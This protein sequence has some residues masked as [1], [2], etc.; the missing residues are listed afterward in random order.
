MTKMIAISTL[1]GVVFLRFWSLGSSIL[2][3]P[4]QSRCFLR[5]LTPGRLKKRRD[6]SKGTAGLAGQTPRGALKVFDA[7]ILLS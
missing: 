1:F 7:S 3:L 4:P 6:Q 2:G 5:K